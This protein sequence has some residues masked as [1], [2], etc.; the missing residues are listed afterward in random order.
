MKTAFTYNQYGV[1]DSISQYRNINGKHYECLTCDN[2]IFEQLK[3]EAKQLG[4]GYRI[5]KGEFYREVR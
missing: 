3:S 2:T 1:K 4:V 5:I